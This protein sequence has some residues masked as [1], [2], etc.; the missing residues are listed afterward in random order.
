[1]NIPWFEKLSHI[2][3]RELQAFE[4][5]SIDYEINEAIKA[6]G[7]L[8]I[9][10]T[11][12]PGN[13]YFVNAKLDEAI[14]FIAV[15]PDSYPF[16]RPQVFASHL[17]LVR[18][19]NP[20]EKNLCL[21]GRSTILWDSAITVPKL[22]ELQLPQLL[23]KGVIVDPEKIKND[24]AEQAEPVSE[25]YATAEH[26]ILFDPSIF[27]EIDLEK[28]TFNLIATIKLGR[29]KDEIFPCRMAILESTITS[30]GQLIKVP[31]EFIKKNFTNT[32]YGNI[33]RISELPPGDPKKLIVW[34]REKV[35]GCGGRFSPKRFS[36]DVGNR[37]MLHSVTGLCFHEE[38]EKGVWG[39]GW[40]FHVDSI[41]KN[42]DA[43]GRKLPPTQFTFYLR[44]SDISLLS[45]NLRAPKLA[46]LANK[47][48]SIAGLGALGSFI[49]IEMARSGVNQLELL[50]NDSVDASTTIRWPLGL[51]AVGI[52]KA[53]VLKRFLDSNYPGKTIQTHQ[54]MI[55][56]FRKPD[57][58]NQILPSSE[59]DVL[60]KFLADTSLVIDATAE[61][62]VHHYLSQL[63]HE[64]GIP[65]ISVYAT[66]GAYAGSIMRQIP[67]KTGCWSCFRHMENEGSLL[68]LNEDAIGL[69]QPP[70]CGDIT[71]TGA[72]VDLQQ[73]SL[74]ATK[75]AIST[76]CKEEV[77]GYPLVDWHIARVNL[78]SEN[79]EFLVPGWHTYDLPIH[80]DCHY[81]N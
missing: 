35:N 22:L 1:M 42:K 55:G 31:I 33:Y 15:Y 45:K 10:F 43:N 61:F 23:E 41:I 47:K 66:P 54:W 17:E 8:Q 9:K 13:H 51:P 26:P 7:V 3:S 37:I 29:H 79:G 2:Y 21:I 80:A 52:N 63:A 77:E 39:Y 76:L 71:F 46:P 25:F 72:S 57:E 38:K 59:S 49:A 78:F 81:C 30:T 28:N 65:Y 73:I 56:T 60:E 62:G 67:G 36:I 69:I 75:L 58:H 74:M 48:I 68:E 40:L 18:H 12:E 34:L 24:P 6:K 70:G 44:G 53:E 64:R 14:E 32:F 11:V 5:F 27:P 16:F 19:Q 50:D 20:I 4:D